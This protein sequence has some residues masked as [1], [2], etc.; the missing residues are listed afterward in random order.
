MSIL[1][2]TFVVKVSISKCNFSPLFVCYV[3]L[4]IFII[5]VKLLPLKKQAK[6]QEKDLQVQILHNENIVWKIY[7]VFAKFMRSLKP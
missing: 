3:E 2:L 1:I 5:K 4:I 6:I 7:E